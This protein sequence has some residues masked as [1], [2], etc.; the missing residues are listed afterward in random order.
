[1]SNPVPFL[2]RLGEGSGAIGAFVSAMGCSMCFPAIASF[3]A[4]IGLGFL[5]RW[6]QLFIHTLMPLFAVL[7]L[8]AAALG[9]LAHHN[10]WRSLLGMIGP[11]LVLVALYPLFRSEMRNPVLYSGLALMLAYSIW[12]IFLRRRTGKAAA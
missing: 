9:W 2:S 12:D 3:G 10:V 4:A 7:A 11:A 1:M 8:L 6:E 5:S